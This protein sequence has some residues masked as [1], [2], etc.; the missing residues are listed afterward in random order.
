MGVT[1]LAIGA[2]FGSLLHLL[3]KVP[4]LIKFGFRWWPVLD[5][6]SQAVRRVLVLMGPR[7]LDLFVFQFTLI[8]M[9]NLASRLRR[10]QRQFRRVGLGR[11]ATAGDA[12]RHRVWAGGLP[13]HGRAGRAA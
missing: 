7:V 6:K 2:V 9:T 1:G 8:M 12:D 10:R 11:D 5:L 13:H 3:I 4:G